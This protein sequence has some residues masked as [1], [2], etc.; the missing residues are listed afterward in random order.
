MRLR[1]TRGVEFVVGV[2]TGRWSRKGFRPKE[3][4]V[5]GDRWCDGSWGQLMI[6]AVMKHE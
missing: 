5:R 3:E 4:D 2:R 1:K 6:G